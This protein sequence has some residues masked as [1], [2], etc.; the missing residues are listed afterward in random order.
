LLAQRTAIE[1][2]L[3]FEVEW[4]DKPDRKASK[5]VS[6]RPGDLLDGAQSQELVEWLVTRADRFAQVLAKYL[7]NRDL[8]G[9]PE[10]QLVLERQS[11]FAQRPP[12]G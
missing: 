11:G 6:R 5:L 1:A 3:G 9:T 12:E 2:D 7:Q 8:Q 4:D 10:D